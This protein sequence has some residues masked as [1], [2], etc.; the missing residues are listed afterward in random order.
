MTDSQHLIEAARAAGY[1]V[2][3]CEQLRAN[4]WLLTL[5]DPSRVRIAV[6]VQ[7]RPLIVAT[8]VQD[9]AEMV[10]LRRCTRGLLWASDGRLSPEA[11][12]TLAEI[13]GGRLHFCTELPPTR[14]A[15]SEVPE[16]RRLLDRL[17]PSHD[18]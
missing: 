1:V 15:T 5:R 10:Q 11:T 12:Q 13:G 16:P 18:K 7:A 2:R 4:R 3:T 6:L 8:D 14:A 9:L 17:K